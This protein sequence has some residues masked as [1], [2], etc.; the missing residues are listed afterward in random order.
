[1]NMFEEIHFDIQWR[2][3][4]PP[5]P[6]AYAGIASKGS[7][8]TVV[9]LKRERRTH[10]QVVKAKR[11]RSILMEKKRLYRE[12]YYASRNKRGTK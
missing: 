4:K 1:M 7:T 2:K 5:I 11:E 3:W 9:K 10:D 12:A 8:M 6:R